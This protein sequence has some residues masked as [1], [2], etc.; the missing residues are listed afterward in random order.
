M[1]DADFEELMTSVLSKRLGG[2]QAMKAACE[3]SG[4]QG[5]VE[6]KTAYLAIWMETATKMPL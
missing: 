4:K 1:R 2:E 6:V 3:D 5:P